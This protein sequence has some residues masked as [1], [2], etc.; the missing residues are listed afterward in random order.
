MNQNITFT[1]LF[2][3]LLSCESVFINRLKDDV[4]VD[5]EHVPLRKSRAKEKVSKCH[6]SVMLTRASEHS[7][8]IRWVNSY[9]CT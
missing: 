1:S 4:A 9:V 7:I 8:S 2:F 6:R 5:Y 3:F